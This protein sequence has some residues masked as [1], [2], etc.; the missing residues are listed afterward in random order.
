MIGAGQRDTRVRFERDAGPV[1]DDHG[2]E[3]PGWA[4][5][6]QCWAAFAFGTGTERRAAAQA[7]SSLAASVTV[8]ANSITRTLTT[9][10]RMLVGTA[11]WNIV[12]VTP[13]R[14][15]SEMLVT[16]VRGQD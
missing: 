4:V 16:V 6:A 2:G 10:D 11:V 15:R 12:G 5:I 14:D 9:R 3:T 13:S 8:L 1:T 7:A